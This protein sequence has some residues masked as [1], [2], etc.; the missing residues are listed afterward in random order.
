MKKKPNLKESA[1]KDIQNAI[2]TLEQLYTEIPTNPIA[3]ALV[4]LELIL[5]EIKK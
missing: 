1:I 2:Q 4:S 5:Q 3:K